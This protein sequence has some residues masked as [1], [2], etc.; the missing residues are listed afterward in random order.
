MAKF[1]DYG[2]TAKDENGI[3]FA[4]GRVVALSYQSAWGKAV[5]EAF[6]SIPANTG[7]RVTVI[8]VW[9][10]HSPSESHG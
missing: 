4:T 7:Q 10:V 3:D 2:W 6:D 5:A 9:R 8:E 1:N